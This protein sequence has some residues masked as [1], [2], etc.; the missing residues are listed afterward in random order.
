[1]LRKFNA[2]QSHDFHLPKYLSKK[3][4]FGFEGNQS[5]MVKIFLNFTSSD[6]SFSLKQT[7][8]ITSQK[9]HN[10]DSNHSSFFN[11]IVGTDLI[12]YGVMVSRPNTQKLAICL[13]FCVNL[14]RPYRLAHKYFSEPLHRK[15][16]IVESSFQ[17]VQVC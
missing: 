10:Q 6:L 17:C 5:N 11:T 16:K 14:N 2:Q 13:L 3:S 12:F 7:R 15:L 9:N 1:M 8:T 4:S